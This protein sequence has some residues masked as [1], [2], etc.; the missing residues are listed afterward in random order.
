L[1]K[2]LDSVTLEWHVLDI[3]PEVGEHR[4]AGGIPA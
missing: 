2:V 3:V 4:K 1:K